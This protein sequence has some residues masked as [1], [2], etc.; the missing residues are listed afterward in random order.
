M[1]PADLLASEQF[2]AESAAPSSNSLRDSGDT[3]WSHSHLEEAL[4]LV[5]FM[6][7]LAGKLSLLMP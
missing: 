4:K 1:E 7:H 5:C 3:S 6:L 2:S